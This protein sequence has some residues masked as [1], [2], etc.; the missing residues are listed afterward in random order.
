M[1][2]E[3]R[4][5][6]SFEASQETSKS[7]TNQKDMNGLSFGK[8]WRSI[9]FNIFQKDREDFWFF[10]NFLKE[11]QKKNF[12]FNFHQTF[13]EEYNSEFVGIQW[14]KRLYILI[15]Q[16]EA[17]LENPQFGAFLLF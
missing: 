2:G 16:S 9:I 3:R 17:Y 5:I 4:E 8:N 10:Q 7:S 14:Y 15:Y 11:K 13:F 1:K 6:F 12:K